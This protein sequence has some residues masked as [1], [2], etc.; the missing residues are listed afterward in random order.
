LNLTPQQ[1]TDESGQ[2]VEF[3]VQTNAPQLFATLPTI[4]PAGRLRFTPSTNASGNAAVTVRLRDNGSADGLNRNISDPQTFTITVI[5]T[6]DDPSG[7]DDRFE[8]NEDV[9][10]QIGAPGVLAN[11]NDIDLPGDQLTVVLVN[12]TSALGAPVVLN[13]D[14]SFTYDPRNVRSLQAMVEGQSQSD[15]FTYRVRDAAGALSN[16]TT[17]SITVRGVNDAPVA[18]ADRFAIA[19]NQTITLTVLSN[20]TDVDTPIDD[21]TI[22]I[23]RLAVNGTARALS[24]GRIEYIPN[25]G[26]RGEDTFT[27]RVRDSLGLLSNEA[28]VT[29]RTNAAPVAVP[30][31]ATTPAG[32]PVTIN[33]LAN[34]FDSDGTINASTVSIVIAP[35]AGTAI[36]NAAGAIEYTPAANFTGQATLSYTV[37]DNEGV[38]SNVAAVNIRVSSSAYQNPNNNLDVNADGFISA[39]DALLIINDLNRSGSRALPPGSFTPPPFIDVN[40]SASVEPLDALLVINHL[41]RPGNGEG[42]G[43]DETALTLP[44]MAFPI[45]V[46]PLSPRA[47]AD[48]E[49]QARVRQAIV[50]LSQGPS[51][52]ASASASSRPASVGSFDYDWMDEAAGLLG[53]DDC[54]SDAMAEDWNSAF[55]AEDWLD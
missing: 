45:D 9:V 30:D 20:D 21:R 37:R 16:V 22:E 46:S 54:D 27:Y 44:I 24:T 26:F 55:G 4:D 47:I 5:S 42:E 53:C 34:D 3:E 7:T 36:V 38:E 12:P 39:I 14:G 50:Q 1:A 28:E 17:V 8:G 18:A 31:A 15:S 35:S 48:L 23:R 11:D 41:N 51:V 13:A 52:A 10:L 6:N 33:V 32:V 49:S 2:T 29:I 43:H 40:G 19:A 25:P